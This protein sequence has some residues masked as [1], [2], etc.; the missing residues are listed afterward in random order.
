MENMSSH[1]P[2]CEHLFARVVILLDTSSSVAT[3]DVTSTLPA[4][5]QAA[6]DMLARTAQLLLES[7][8]NRTLLSVVDTSDLAK[9]VI[10]MRISM[11]LDADELHDVIL[12]LPFT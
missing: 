11:L 4:T 2:Q 3:R 12:A 6:V 8:T 5:F 10:Q 1:T 9:E 7:A